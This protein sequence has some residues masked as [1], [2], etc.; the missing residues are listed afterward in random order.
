MENNVRGTIKPKSLRP[1][2]STDLGE[3]SLRLSE[4]RD[5]LQSTFNPFSFIKNIT[6][7]NYL[8]SAQLINRSGGV[9]KQLH[10]ALQRDEYIALGEGDE[11]LANTTIDS[12]WQKTHQFYFE[13]SQSGDYISF[14]GRSLLPFRALSYCRQKDVYLELPCPH[15]GGL[16]Q[17]CC[18]DAL[19]QSYGLPTYSGSLRRF[20]YCPECPTGNEVFFYVKERQTN[21]PASVV[22][23]AAMLASL[24]ELVVTVQP[25]PSF[26]CI[27]C[28]HAA[29]CYGPQQLALSRLVPLSFHD[30]YL[31][32]FSATPYSARDYLKELARPAQ[33]S[34]EKHSDES[35]DAE[36]SVVS[37]RRHLLF[38]DDKRSFLEILLLK[39]A[40]LQQVS[41]LVRK[42]EPCLVHQA[43]A[44][45]LSSLRVDVQERSGLL[46]WLWN[47]RV[48]PVGVFPGADLS[49]AG[50][51]VPPAISFYSLALIWFN[52][53]LE[54]SIQGHGS[55]RQKLGDLL[56][57]GGQPFQGDLQW[58]GSLKFCAPENIYDDPGS[59]TVDEIFFP[60]WQDTLNQ[61]WQLLQAAYQQQTTNWSWDVFE[62]GIS[63]LYQG[64]RRELFAAHALGETASASVLTEQ[65]RQNGSARLKSIL[66][67]IRNRW[68]QQEEPPKQFPDENDLERTQIM[69]AAPAETQVAKDDD[70][71]RTVILEGPQPAAVKSSSTESEPDHDLDRTVVLQPGTPAQSAERTPSPPENDD[72]QKT[73]VL[74]ASVRGGTGELSEQNVSHGTAAAPQEPEEVAKPQKKQGDIL[75]ETLILSPEE[76]AK[77]LGK[78]KP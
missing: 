16:L 50:L 9:I 56:A 68:V 67:D 12:F 78:K 17:D 11:G 59:I 51:P 6:P 22:D 61:G 1:W 2:L 47:F 38:G 52:V 60:F 31:L 57:A 13:Q 5:N 18:D 69:P 45:S 14:S 62:D 32:G 54:N 71:Q 35:M 76:L 33:K 49:P 26:P 72:L 7:L 3:V 25:S 8:L 39:I 37:D 36:A 19:L 20:R 41:E 73:V 24:G 29:E 28:E 34:T 30:F 74:T 27:G 75:P 64:I 55:I 40:F 43:L 65:I 23:W 10:L 48:K 58:R 63:C 44:P 53:L 15:C 21:D 46:P 77:L 70:L 4:E 66:L 42:A